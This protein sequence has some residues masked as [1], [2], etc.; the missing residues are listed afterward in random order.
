MISS[1]SEL[2]I[3]YFKYILTNVNW[4]EGMWGKGR[5]ALSLQFQCSAVEKLPHMLVCCDVIHYFWRK[6]VE[7]WNQQ[8]GDNYSVNDFYG[9]NP[10][11]R[12]SNSFNYYI[13][14]GK[15]YQFAKTRL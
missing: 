2:L 14:L 4:I 6:A 5:G 15:I 1:V 9:Y 3:S 12:K 13:L 7:W 10:E 8:N 11:T